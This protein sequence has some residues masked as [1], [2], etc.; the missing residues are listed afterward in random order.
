MKKRKSAAAAP[1]EPGSAM[2]ATPD[3]TA[4]SGAGNWEGPTQVDALALDADDAEILQVV[5]LDGP[6]SA[7]DGGADSEVTATG[8]DAA[9][10]SIEP[11]GDPAAEGSE[12]DAGTEQADA[13]GEE[14]METGA[15]SV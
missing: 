13:P 6:P 1:P 2:P 14:T 10:G 5:D 4:P 15:G 11:V 12:L 8:T 7:G 3:A 9:G